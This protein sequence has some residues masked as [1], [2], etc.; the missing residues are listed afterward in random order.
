MADLTVR[1]NR[2][3]LQNPILVASGTFGYAKEM[4]AFVPFSK[5]G[6][7]VPKTVTPLPRIGN[8]PPRT[9]E[10]CAG[11]LNSIGLDNDGIDR[12]LEK[13]LPYLRD[14]G[15]S[16]LVNIAGHD[17]DEFVRMAELLDGHDGIAGVEL[18]IS[19]PNVAGGTDFSLCTQS[20]GDIIT[21]VRKAC[22]FPILAKLTPMVSKI[23]DIA[24]AARDAGVDAVVLS[25]T[26]PG[27][28]IDWRRRRPMLGNVVGGLSGP[29]I[30]PVVLR[31]V[32]LVSQAVGVPVIGVGGISTFDDVMEFLVAGATA[33]QIGT[34]NF[35]NPTLSARLVDELDQTLNQLGLPAV[36]NVIGTL[37]VP[38][39]SR[40]AKV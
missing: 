33:V 8:P 23:V 20:T 11:M 21:R 39:G 31:L 16:I 27:M 37:E 26:I 17:P 5:L 30:K 14:L 15:T 4:E 24:K 29:A 34:A 10:T 38:D 3:T 40:P 25:N 18:N 6:G 9:Y 28:A 22:R 19:C 12:F 7:I 32:W 2:L 35:F 36:Q 13:H 1:L